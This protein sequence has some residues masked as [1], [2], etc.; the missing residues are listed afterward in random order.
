MNEKSPSQKRAAEISGLICLAV[1]LFLMLALLSYHPLDPSFTH[2]VP[3]DAPL[4]NWTGAA[5]SYTADTLLRLLGIGILWLPVLLLVAAFL[6]FR[7]PQFRIWAAAAAG[8]ASLV[9]ATS[10][11]FALL[12]GYIKIYGI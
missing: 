3:E 12:I 10:C 2:Y 8:L 1:A 4:H 9:F 7:E 11:L 6:Y 5:G